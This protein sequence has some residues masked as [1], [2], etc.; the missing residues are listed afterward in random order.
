MKTAKEFLKSEFCDH[1]TEEGRAIEFAKLHVKQALEAANKKGKIY[2]Y[3]GEIDDKNH[4][5][6]EE[7]IL[8]SYP[9]SNIK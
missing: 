3:D 1:L 7:S 6:N 9:L 4:Y 2:N 5:I 8:N